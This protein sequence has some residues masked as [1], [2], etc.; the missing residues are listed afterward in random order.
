M[1][2]PAEARQ[3]FAVPS[4]WCV[5]EKVQCLRPG[6]RF[7]DDRPVGSVP[8]GT[9][10]LLVIRVPNQQQRPPVAGAPAGL[11]MH[12]GHQGAGRVEHV[13]PACVRVPPHLRGDA[14]RGEDTRRSAGKTRLP[15]LIPLR[16]APRRPRRNAWLASPNRASTPVGG[17]RV[18]LRKSYPPLDAGLTAGLEV[19]PWVPPSG[20]QSAE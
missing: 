3:F 11:L 8:V 2:D 13:Q 16:S 17:N 19:R 14:V 15:P 9:L 12:L 7:D 1:A 6:D 20:Y 18:L 10:D 5:G 4:P